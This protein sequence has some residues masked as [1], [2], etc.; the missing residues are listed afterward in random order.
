MKR[1]LQFYMSWVLVFAWMGAIFYFSSQEGLVSHQKSFSVANTIEKAI[2]M[3][4]QKDII[5]EQNYKGFEFLIRKIAHVTE[6]F[7]LS[8]LFLRAFIAS[9]FSFKKS[10]VF[11]AIFSILYAA[12]DEIHQIFVSDRGPSPVDV[13]IDSIGILGYLVIRLFRNINT[14]FKLTL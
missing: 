4:L 6:Y 11:T 7:I 3:I 5:T 9:K 8:F 13:M 2:E 14:V 10:I 12:T 1:N